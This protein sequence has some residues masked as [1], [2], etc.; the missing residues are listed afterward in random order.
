MS[1]NAIDKADFYYSDTAAV[2]CCANCGNSSGNGA[3]LAD[4]YLEDGGTLLL[5]DD[6]GNEELRAE[7]LR[8]L[9]AASSCSELAGKPVG[10]VSLEQAVA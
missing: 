7:K 5:C 1:C 8:D 3:Y 10:S 9:A 4:F 6:C 2:A